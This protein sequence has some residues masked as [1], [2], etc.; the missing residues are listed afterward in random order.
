MWALRSGSSCYCLLMS[1]PS[2]IDHAPTRFFRVS[3]P[4]SPSFGDY[5]IIVSS[6]YLRCVQTAVAIADELDLVVLLDQASG[7][8]NVTLYKW[9]RM[10]SVGQNL[11]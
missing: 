9:L 4:A 5:G 3:E 11:F 8:E 1:W 10:S 7:Q 2:W 6:P